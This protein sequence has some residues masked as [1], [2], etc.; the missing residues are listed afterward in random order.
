MN[1]KPG[2]KTAKVAVLAG[3]LT[4]AVADPLNE[5][6]KESISTDIDVHTAELVAQPA[7]SNWLSYNGDFSGRRYSRLSQINRGNVGELRAQW[8]FHSS[9]SNR[10][11]VT[12]IVVNGIMFVTSA[13][14]TFALIGSCT[15]VVGP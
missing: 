5:S 2:H 10:L 7:G 3:Y 4:L 9:N 15:F 14:D 11:E 12:P 13:N 6:P 8:V 1:F